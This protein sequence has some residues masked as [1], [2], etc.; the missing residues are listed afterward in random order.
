MSLLAESG[1]IGNHLFRIP[2]NFDIKVDGQRLSLEKRSITENSSQ[3][4]QT[5]RFQKC[6]KETQMLIVKA[7]K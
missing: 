1:K 3:D 4:Y 5:K 7:R 6:S 2:I